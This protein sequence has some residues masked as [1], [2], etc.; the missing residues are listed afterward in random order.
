MASRTPQQIRDTL[1]KTAN[2]M[3]KLRSSVFNAVAS[4][5]LSAV[6]LLDKIIKQR[7]KGEKS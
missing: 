5:I 3:I 1:A 7:K 6:T 4:R 2:D